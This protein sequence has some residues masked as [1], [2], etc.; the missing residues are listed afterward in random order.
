MHV[1][2]FARLRDNPDRLLD[3]RATWN[4]WLSLPN[5]SCGKPY[6]DGWIKAIDEGLDAVEKLIRDEGDWGQVMRSCSPFGVLWNSPQERW[7]Y[8]RWW[9]REKMPEYELTRK[10][11]YLKNDTLIQIPLRKEEE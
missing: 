8:I 11:A 7:E 5:F 10:P 1:Y 3:L 4:Y 6:V 2:L 9:K